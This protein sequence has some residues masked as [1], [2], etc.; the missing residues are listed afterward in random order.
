MGEE[1][2]SKGYP[3]IKIVAC[4]VRPV[5]RI[6]V[7][8][9]GTELYTYQ[10]P[11]KSS[12][13]ITILWKERLNR[14]GYEGFR[15]GGEKVDWICQIDVHNGRLVNAGYLSSK[16][17][18]HCENPRIKILSHKGNSLYLSAVTV[19]EINGIQL[20]I[21]NLTE[22]TII[23][24]YCR[25]TG[26]LSF[27]N[28]SGIEEKSLSDNREVIIIWGRPVG[29]CIELNFEDSSFPSR[30][31]DYYYVRVTQIDGEMAWSSPIWVS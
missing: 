21:E 22:K 23:D 15:W 29:G 19:G 5:Y 18:H 27:R 13:K 26:K 20:E 11:V 28:N 16:T 31:E 17:N 9:N 24:F 25:E 8:K 12:N 2:K 10:H 30:G 1:I 14:Y 7:I 4:G 6:D 3:A